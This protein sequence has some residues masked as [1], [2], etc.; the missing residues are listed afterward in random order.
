[1]IYNQNAITTSPFGPTQPQFNWQGFGQGIANNPFINLGA[2]LLTATPE[3]SFGGALG[4][5]LRNMQL[6]Q[7]NNM[8]TA[9]M[10]QQVKDYQERRQARQ[11][12][13]QAGQQLY[14]GNTQALLALQAGQPALAAQLAYPTP[15]GPMS[16][17]G[18]LEADR[19]A[20]RITEEQYNRQLAINM[21]PLTTTTI[22]N[23]PR[24]E[25]TEARQMASTEVSTDLLQRM[26]QLALKDPDAIMSP[27]KKLIGELEAAPF[28]GEAIQS[29][30]PRTEAQY[31]M[32]SMSEQASNLLLQA[33]RG[34]QVGPAEQ[35]RFERQLPIQGQPIKLFMENLRNTQRNLEILNRRQRE[36]RQFAPTQQTESPQLPARAV[37]YN[38]IPLEMLEE[39]ARRR[40]LE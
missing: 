40:G 4:L 24:P 21:R 29:V 9:L 25:A 19:A 27:T 28:V 12:Q 31:Q 16:P 18:K 10:A 23:I 35:E 5:G 37:D 20:G 13:E 15:E 3:A 22:K 26:E 7:R 8:A 32:A 34:A 36:M 14:G 33:M 30:M 6:A 11:R 38:S 39:D 2:G 1:M 17:M